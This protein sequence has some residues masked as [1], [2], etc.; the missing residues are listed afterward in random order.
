[1]NSHENFGLAFNR[2]LQDLFI[3]RMD[4]NGAIFDKF[5]TDPKFRQAVEQSLGREV[6]DQIRGLAEG[7][8]G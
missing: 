7:A 1:M 8:G 3:D 2:K 4:Q 5:M 6:Y